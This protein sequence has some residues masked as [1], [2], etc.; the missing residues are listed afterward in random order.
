M[1]DNA[2]FIKIRND[3]SFILAKSLYLYEHQSTYNPNMPLR[4]FFY[5]ADLYKR[6]VDKSSL[7]YKTLVKI[8]I[9]KYVVFYNGTDKDSVPDI[10]YLRLSDAF[11]CE[12]KPA[13]FEWTATMIN[14]NT[15]SNSELMKKCKIISDYSEFVSTI[16]KYNCEYE[17]KDAILKAV[18]YCIKNDILKEILIKFRNEVCIMSWDEFDEEEFNNYVK[19]RENEMLKHIM[20]LQDKNDKLQ[21]KND[22]LQ[23]EINL[24]KEQLDAL[25]NN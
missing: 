12:E 22:E 17:L 3:V 4:G 1:L 16:R 23:K 6:I 15:G 9:P 5:F 21:D 24:L 19:N 8:P 2:I 18:E 11:D 20:E 7:F 14:I 10:S 13:G 25:K